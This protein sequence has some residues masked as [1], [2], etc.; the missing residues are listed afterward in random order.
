[1]SNPQSMMV[2]IQETCESLEMR[3]RFPWLSTTCW[4]SNIVL[5]ESSTFQVWVVREDILLSISTCM[6]AKS[7]LRSTLPVFSCLETLIQYYTFS[8]YKWSRVRVPPAK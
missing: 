5:R 6:S 2:V 8:M 4:C 7:Y 3:I 1:M